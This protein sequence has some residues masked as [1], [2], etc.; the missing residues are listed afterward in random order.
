MFLKQL[1]RRK[2]I[3]V[4]LAEMAGENQLHRVLGPVSLTALGVGAIIGAGIFVTTGRAAAIDAGPA[5]IIS[6]TVAA[7]GCAFAALCYAEFA[8]MAPVAGSA[9][10][11]AYATLGEL[12]AWIIGWDLMLEYAMSCATVASAWS[13][14][15]NELLEALHLPRVAARWSSDPFSYADGAPLTFAINLPAILIMLLITAVLIKG[16]RESAST[17]AVLVLVKLAVVVFVIVLGW[18][19]VNQANWTDIPSN[20]RILPEQS[21]IPK[22]A[23]DHLIHTEKLSTAEAIERAPALQQH[24]LAAYKLERAKAETERMLEEKDITPLEAE[25]ALAAAKRIHEPSLATTPEEKAEAEKLLAE[26]REKAPHMAAEKW[27]MI[28]LLG[29]NHYLVPIDDATRSPFIPYGISGIMLGASIVFFAYIGF[30][31]ISTHAEEA[32]RPQRDVPMAILISLGLCTVLYIAVSAVITGL[33]PYPT[34]DDK[35]PIA[36]AFSDLAHREQSSSLRMA[37]AVIAAGGLAG[38]TS[39]LLVT[40]LSQVRVFM[41]MSRDGLLPPIFGHVHPRFRT[42]HL[43]TMLTGAV[44]CVVTAFTPIRKLEEMVNIGTLMAF[45]V[46]CAA[47]LILRVRQPGV[48][49]PFV[50]PV[51]YLVAPLGIFVNLALMLFLPWDTWLRLA[52]W[53]GVGLVI[54]LGYSRFHSRLAKETLHEIKHHGMTG[55]DTPLRG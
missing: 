44:I 19:Y 4:L 55:S 9:Y 5:I 43:A 39:V 38:M 3:E 13:G 21:A 17:N 47:V 45:V 40:F 31:S 6:Y 18:S 27:G 24:A 10:T 20:E 11:Y 46:V 37:T 54:Y 25:E 7:I 23:K 26:V 42:P 41:A 51:I 33:V 49:R 8:A 53:L 28:G 12:F 48:H 50:C 22:L 30:D 32:I 1:L 34:I 29:L 14:Y 36:K 52:V 2:K 35:A 16:I 15:L